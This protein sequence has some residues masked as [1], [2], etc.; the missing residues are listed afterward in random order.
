MKGRTAGSS[1][2][3]A[4]ILLAALILGVITVVVCV[5]LYVLGVFPPALAKLIGTVS[6]IV[7]AMSVLMRFAIKVEKVREG[8]RG[9]L[10]IADLTIVVLIVVAFLVVAATVGGLALWAAHAHSAD[11]QRSTTVYIADWSAWSAS[12]QWQVESDNRT[13]DGVPV[14]AVL[15]S[16]GSAT[17]CDPGAIDLIAPVNS[18]VDN[19]A[20]E[21]R[22]Q[23][24]GESPSAQQGEVYFG[25]LIQADASGNGNLIGVLD[26]S[27]NPHPG[28]T[29]LSVIGSD[30]GPTLMRPYPLDEG[31][32]VYRVEVRGFR[33]R[34]LI[35]GKLMFQATTGAYRS[36]RG[37]GIVNSGYEL[38]V[39][40]LTVYSL[41]GT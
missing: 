6:A 23:V 27:P 19:Y 8:I 12:G 14:S 7:T 31:S 3:A 4:D 9:I 41:A 13:V 20:I 15:L 1:Q 16:D 30:N 21:M 28:M 32:H 39:S 40:R 25:V 29:F 34:F 10:R 11:S 5:A 2:I 37:F 35:D 24:S 18:P 36:N 38:E 26:D 22:I 33:V 17:C